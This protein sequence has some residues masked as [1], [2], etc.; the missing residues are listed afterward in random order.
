[1]KSPL[2]PRAALSCAPQSHIPSAS[3]PSFSCSP[4]IASSPDP[5]TSAQL[6]WTCPDSSGLIRHTHI[7][8]HSYKITWFNHQL[9]HCCEPTF[10]SIDVIQEV[11]GVFHYTVADITIITKRQKRKPEVNNN[12]KITRECEFV[13]SSAKNIETAFNRDVFI[14]NQV[15]VDIGQILHTPPS[16]LEEWSSW[17]RWSSPV[18]TPDPPCSLC[19]A[20]GPAWPAEVLSLRKEINVSVNYN[21]TDDNQ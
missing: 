14:W 2:P 11:D 8:T 16:R 19:D 7:H 10:L 21:T 3:P 4:Q 12:W 15:D 17:W 18:W 6:A 1:M 5:E 20:G 9:I 13:Q